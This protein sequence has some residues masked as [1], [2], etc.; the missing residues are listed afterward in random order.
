MMEK[1]GVGFHPI[2]GGLSGNYNV[3]N[4]QHKYDTQRWKFES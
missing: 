2:L 3:F 4:E 1:S